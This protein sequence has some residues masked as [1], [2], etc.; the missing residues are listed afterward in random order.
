MYRSHSGGM[1]LALGI[2]SKQPL[3]LAFLGGHSALPGFPKD[4]EV[5]ARLLATS[6]TLRPTAEL[7][8]GI[9]S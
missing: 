8:H 5:A 1:A 3:T 6:L 2:A 9:E 4:T 7:E